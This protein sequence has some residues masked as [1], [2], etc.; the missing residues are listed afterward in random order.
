[1]PRVA[2]GL[3]LGV[4]LVLGCGGGGT[5]GGGTP[6]IGKQIIGLHD[7]CKGIAGLTGGAILDRRVDQFSATLGFFD[8][9]GARVD[10][11]ALKIDLTWPE[12]P[13]AIC[14]E[15]IYETDTYVTPRVAIEGLTMRFVTADGK[16]QETLAAKAWLPVAGGM[17]LYPLILAVTVR[18]NL[19]GSW[20]PRPEE[21]GD[22]L[23]FFI[24]LG[25]AD[26]AVYSG[27]IG[28]GSE[29]PGELDA[30]IFRDRLTIANWQT[31]DAPV[32]R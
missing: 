12:P 15:P 7:P 9:E 23:G 19:H 25:Y 10:P 26:S 13:A 5:L 31:G 17:L 2:K 16:F 24:V 32:A 4:V 8:S 3:S 30:A 22:T 21:Q 27:S 14:Y 1:M 11:T 18:S 20:Q 6:A 28:L 29:L